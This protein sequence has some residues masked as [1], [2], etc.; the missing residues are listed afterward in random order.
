MHKLTVKCWLELG[1][2]FIKFRGESYLHN[3][4]PNIEG[5]YSDIEKFLRDL[6]PSYRLPQVNKPFKRKLYITRTELMLQERYTSL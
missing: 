1:I 5:V 6:E 3:R 2:D 4:Y